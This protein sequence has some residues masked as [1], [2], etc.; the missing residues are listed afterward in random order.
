M[1]RESEQTKRF[2]VQLVQLYGMYGLVL[3]KMLR[4]IIM[5]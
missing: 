4:A 5:W 1:K 2:T 3:N